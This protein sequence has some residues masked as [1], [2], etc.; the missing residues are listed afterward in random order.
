MNGLRFTNFGDILNRWSLNKVATIVNSV[1]NYADL[2]GYE[3]VELVSVEDNTWSDAINQRYDV[4][5]RFM[6]GEKRLVGQKLLIL[7]GE[8]IDGLEF[9]KRFDEFY[10]NK[11]TA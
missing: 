3:N 1:K 4:E 2:K 9:H 11:R 8:V 7:K 5:I 6:D 10:P